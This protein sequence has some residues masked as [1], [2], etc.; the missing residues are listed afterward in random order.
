MKYGYNL[1]LSRLQSRRRLKMLT[2]VISDTCLKVY[3]MYMVND[4]PS[5]QS[6]KGKLYMILTNK[7]WQSENSNIVKAH[8][9]L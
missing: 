1:P 4:V 6:F 3:Y 2:D 7:T 5:A 9:S 8:W